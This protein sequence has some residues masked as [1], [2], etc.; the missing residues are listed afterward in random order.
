MW[1]VALRSSLLAARDRRQALLERRFPSEFPAIV[2]LSLNLP[3]DRKTGARAE[4][5]FRWGEQALLAA[6]PARL[7]TRD[8]DALG[9]FALY[10]VSLTAE[11]A[12][13]KAIEVEAAHPAGRLLDL[14]IYD[15]AGRPVDRA[16]LGLSPRTCLLC[17]E[18]AVACI[19]AQR[20]Q[21]AELQARA[22]AVIDAI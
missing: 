21:G 6:L 9:P 13:L 8:S 2:M 11:P 17:S 18:A 14:D 1:Y 3:G 19:R 4:R 12:K 10:G 20:H 15:P 7:L 22:H 5:L 16:G